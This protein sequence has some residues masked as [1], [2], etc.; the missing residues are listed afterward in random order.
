MRIK[1]DFEYFVIGNWQRWCGRNSLEGG[2]WRQTTTIIITTIITTILISTNQINISFT[3]AT[4]YDLA[5]ATYRWLILD[6]FKEA[7]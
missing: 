3:S 7:L 5:S 6:D 2:A 4:E 1:L